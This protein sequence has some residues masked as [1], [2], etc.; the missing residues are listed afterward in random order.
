MSKLNSKRQSREEKARKESHLNFMG[1]TSF[2]IN[3][4]FLRLRIV[5]ASSFFGE[6]K[7][8]SEQVG[9]FKK[10][11]TIMQVRPIKKDTF[12][13]LVDMLG[14]VSPYEWR[15]M[16]PKSVMEK[17]IDECLDVD[18]E[19]TLVFAANLRNEDMMRSTPQVILVRAACHKNVKGTN[20]IRKYAP[21]ICKR[22]DEPANGLAYYFS[23]FGRGKLPNSLKRAWRDI[24]EGFDDY[25]ISKYRLDNHSVR[26]VDVCSLV[27]A[28]SRAID[29]LFSGKAKQTK[30]WNAIVSNADNSSAEKREKNWERAVEGM[31]HMALLRNLR[32]LAENKVDLNIYRDKLIGGVL[33][34]KQLPFRYFSAYESLK[35]FPEHQDV[36][37][38]CLE[39]SIENVPHFDGKTM[40]LSD[41]SG[42]AMCAHTSEYGSR[43]I[44]EIGNLMSVITAK[45]SDNGY[46]GI[47][48]D[49]LDV[50]PIRKM[51]SIFDD[52]EKCNKSGANIGGATENGIWLFFDRA[53]K[54]KQHW[55]NIFVYSDMQAGHGGLYGRDY[56]AYEDYTI[57]SHYIDVAKLIKEY[58]AKVNPNVMIYLVQI[59]G[60]QD[61]LVPEFYDKTFIIGG[62]STGVLGFAKEM[63]QIFKK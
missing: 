29:K 49:R 22:G 60:Y 8:Y 14:E 23:E 20:L 17:C 26:T 3:D 42:S 52:L 30:T 1:G 27:H 10:N 2:D 63:E 16:S 19:R 58:R 56:H 34:G 31:P 12:K 24:L 25:V 11:K 47:F 51:S 62:W 6:P 40:C 57:N 55:D 35:G 15:N 9:D 44:S 48:G 18:P 50:I 43:R 41:N 61:A 53:I 59:A 33:D 38:E 45:S 13:H 36:V 5:A 21:L 4:P 54:E 46:V 28:H 7:Y 39:A 32:N 37:E